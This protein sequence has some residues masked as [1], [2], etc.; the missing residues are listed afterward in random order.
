MKLVGIYFSIWLGMTLLQASD[1]YQ[2][3]SHTPNIIQYP[4]QYVSGW[5]FGTCFI[6]I[7]FH[8]L[9]ISS[10]QLTNPYFSEG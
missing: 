3:E 5:W 7:I 1:T 10:S 9:G 2:G 4:N 8:I 6:W